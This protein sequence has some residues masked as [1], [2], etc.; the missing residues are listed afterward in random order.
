MAAGKFALAALIA[1]GCQGSAPPVKAHDAGPDA[2]DAPDA[3]CG[4]DAA[5][6]VLDWDSTSLT[7]APIAGAAL[8]DRDDP[9]RTVATLADGTWAMCIGGNFSLV[10]M[11]PPSGTDYLPGVEFAKRDVI[12]RGAKLT[13]RSMTAARRAAFFAGVGQTYDA[14]AG[15]VLVNFSGTTP[16]PHKAT[17][18][19]TPA[20]T[21]A[22]NADAWGASDTGEYVFF[23]NVALGATANTVVTSDAS[24]VIGT[25]VIPLEPG[26]ISF[27]ELYVP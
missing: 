9:S 25:A 3:G 2:P 27:V 6:L 18:D 13:A 17:I 5:G 7:V 1:T 12:Q 21:Q 16:A 23:G 11:A 14:N 20:L 22:W 15:Q 8:V 19:H 26:A 4:V 10:D 24:G